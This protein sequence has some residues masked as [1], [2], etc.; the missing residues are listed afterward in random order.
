[1][2]L[3]V[4]NRCLAFITTSMTVLGEKLY[5]GPADYSVGLRVVLRALFV[6]SS[7]VRATLLTTCERLSR[8]WTARRKCTRGLRGLAWE[9][10]L[11]C[12]SGFPLYGVHRFESP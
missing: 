1:M 4:L 11:S 7:R 2:M 9:V 5:G 12:V 6:W 10:Y 8:T 3:S